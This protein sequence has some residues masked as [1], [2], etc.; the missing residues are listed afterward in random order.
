MEFN[1]GKVTNSRLMGSMGLIINWK[2]IDD[3]V[4]CQY[5]LLDSE[6]LGIADYVSLKNPTGHEVFKE[7]ERLTG[8]LGSDKIRIS[9]DEARFLVSY[10][11]NKNEYYNKELP[12]EVDEYIDI[13][14]NY[15]GKLSIEDLFPKICK[16]VD[17]EVEFINYMIM[18]FIAWD[19]VGLRYF[20]GS[21]EVSN[22]H[23]TEINGTLLKTEVKKIG[24]GKYKSIV[25]YEDI[26]GYYCCT[27][28]LNI[29]RE[30]YNKRG[31]KLNSILVISNEPMNDFEVFDEI[32]KPEYIS[33]Y[34]IHD[35]DFEEVFY[36]ENPFLFKSY[37]DNGNLYTRFSFNNN[38][39]K[40]NIYVINNDLKAIYYFTNNNLFVGTYS[41]ED[42]EFINGVINFN[43]SGKLDFIDNYYFNQNALFDFAESGSDDFNDFL[44]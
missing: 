41:K 25:I 33:A 27:L 30:G 1:F 44:S 19:R 11:G 36:D 13:I 2:D 34:E 21:E 24:E 9:E 43:Y 29:E 18:R 23:I 22:M 5:F 38:H 4:F 32:A 6:G 40:E 37:M 28:A 7:E 10:Y 3:K 17:D 16:E 14:N 15:E 35:E 39:V 26:D 42:S 20:S 12:G 8:G 31:L